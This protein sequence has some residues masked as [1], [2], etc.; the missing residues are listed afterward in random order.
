MIPAD[1]C[2]E[3]RDSRADRLPR[4]RV[5]SAR[6]RARSAGQGQ[7]RWQAEKRP[8]AG[9]AEPGAAGS[10]CP[11]GLC[12]LAAAGISGTGGTQVVCWIVGAG[13]VA[14]GAAAVCAA[15]VC[16]AAATDRA[17]SSTGAGLA[18]PCSPVPSVWLAMAADGV[19]ECRAVGVRQELVQRSRPADP[20]HRPA[21]RTA[22]RNI[23]RARERHVV[24][25]ESVMV[26]MKLYGPKPGGGRYGW[27][28]GCGT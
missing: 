24:R 16:A 26:H 15:V 20:P 27:A 1:T 21:V 17:V 4:R 3:H 19:D 9:L 18:W 6:S 2:W 5:F 7:R 12:A 23:V 13:D 11:A 22:R 28:G 14:E 25:L 8:G 10:S